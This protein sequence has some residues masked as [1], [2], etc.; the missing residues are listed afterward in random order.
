MQFFTALL[1]LVL[2]STP[3]LAQGSPAATDPASTGNASLT[4]SP[5]PEPSPAASPAPA[6]G[7]DVIA[8]PPNAGPAGA[9]IVSEAEMTPPAKPAPGT[10]PLPDSSF[11]DPNGVIPDSSTPAASLPAGPTAEEAL[12]KLKIRYKEV[13]VQVEKDPDVLSLVEQSKKAKTFE[14]ERAAL[15]EYY[16][17]LFKKMKKVDKSLTDRCN[18]ME[19]AYLN[20]LTQYRLEPT[21]PLNLPPKPEVLGN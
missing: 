4:P 13:R 7:D 1:F 10:S 19:A 11:T 17:L 21:I 20:R 12:R 15:R 3:L 9:P 16:R 18:A 6:S 2:A 14:E 8:L 5:T